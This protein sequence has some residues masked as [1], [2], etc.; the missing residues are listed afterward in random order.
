MT[1]KLYLFPLFCLLTLS[2]VAQEKDT[3]K[4]KYVPDPG[5]ES[6]AHHRVYSSWGGDGP[7][8]SFSG[9]VRD[10]GQH[11]P[12]IP[13]FTVFFNVG[14]NF[15][16]D[17]SNSFGLFTGI[18]LKNIG[19]ITK[20]N[21]S[22]KLKRRVYTVGVP[23]GFKIGDL[24]KGRLF[25]FAG[26]AYDLAFNY[27]EKQFINGDKRHKFNE[28]FSDR[29]PL[30]MPSLFAGFRF[31]PG[32]GLKVQYYP[33]NFFNKDFKDEHNATPYANLET[34]LFFVTLNYD[35][36]NKRPHWHEHE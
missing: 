1:R 11:V 35:F 21:D 7:L 5:Y 4:F 14:T 20:E 31:F 33:D 24:K 29:T 3:L 15:N 18:N 10:A 30:F 34:K 16:Y 13:R 22:L 12:E 36:S 26:G 17:F 32:I 9:N 27:K 2:V 6:Q 23:L 25:F 8:L 28:W 19:L